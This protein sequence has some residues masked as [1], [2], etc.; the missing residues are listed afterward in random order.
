MV[1]YI[2]S[3]YFV[4]LIFIFKILMVKLK[5]LLNEF[6]PIK[7]KKVKQITVPDSN[8]YYAEILKGLGEY[9]IQLGSYRGLTHYM[10]NTTKTAKNLGQAEKIAKKWLE[11]YIKNPR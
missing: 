9:E 6:T 7:R 4:K 10:I 8:D 5:D 11:D 3:L 2:L 1:R